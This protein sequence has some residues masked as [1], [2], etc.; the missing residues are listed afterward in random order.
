[1][2]H[3]AVI[4]NPIVHSLSPAM[5]AKVFCDFGLNADHQ[6]LQVRHDSL[7]ELMLTM[8]NGDIDG[9]NVTI[10][11]KQAVIQFLDEIDE[12]AK[13]IGA[14][15]CISAKNGKLKGYNTDWIGFIQSLKQLNI[16]NI[17]NR[18]FVVV[19]AGG[20]AS[21]VVYGLVQKKAKSI[22]II[23]RTETKAISL[24]NRFADAD[25]QVMQWENIPNNIL[26]SAIIVNGTSV[27]MSPN[28]NQCPVPKDYIKSGQIAVDIIY[29]PLWTQFRK[30]YSEIGG[31][32][33]SGMPMLVLQGLAAMDI[34][35]DKPLSKQINVLDLI[36]YLEKK[37]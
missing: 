14:V 12:Y 26:N 6:A 25:I 34:W 3:F 21:A 11:Y 8:R 18:H 28:I 19:G 5:Y 16:I 27:G 22:F 20:A 35:Y 31:K 37:L 32:S 10:P 15:N 30:L 23:N 33:I 13:D 2:K 24:K 7:S 29:S 1:M 9:L 4:G 17:P 36:H